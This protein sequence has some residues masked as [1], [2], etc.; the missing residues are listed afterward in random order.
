M[1]YNIVQIENNLFTMDGQL[2]KNPIGRR[3]I[4]IR[5]SNNEL[6]VHSPIYLEHAI[7]SKLDSLGKLTTILVPNKWHTLDVKKVHD[8]YPHSK[9]FVSDGLQKELSKRLPIHGTYEEDW[10]APLS[11]ELD[12]FSIEGLYNPEVVFF[13]KASKT[14]IAADV[15][16][17][18]NHNDFSGFTS[19]LMLLNKATRFGTTR[20]YK[21]SMV[22]DKSLFKASL[23]DILKKWTIDKIIVCHG[24]IIHTNGMIKIQNAISNL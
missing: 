15:F 12:V 20:F 19:L 6:V 2:S 18:F 1:K 7:K 22:K 9:I 24:H 14:L 5:L 11:D 23:A 8:Q 3:L 21:W 17:N 4:V 10:T 13:H 16:F